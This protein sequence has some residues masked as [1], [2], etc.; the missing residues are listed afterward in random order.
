MDR[1]KAQINIIRKFGVVNYIGST[2]RAALPSSAAMTS[3][4]VCGLSMDYVLRRS[5]A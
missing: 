4:F 1:P 2:P 3:T 5:I